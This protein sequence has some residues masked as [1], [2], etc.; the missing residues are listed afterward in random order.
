M[1]LKSNRFLNFRIYSLYK[2]VLQLIGKHVQLLN[3]L[4]KMFTENVIYHLLKDFSE[5]VQ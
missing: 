2:M 4:F 5:A 1:S 3:Y